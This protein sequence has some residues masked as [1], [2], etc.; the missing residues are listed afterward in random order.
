M[1][2]VLD[3]SFKAS[4]FNLQSGFYVHVWNNALGKDMKPLNLPVI[5][6]N[7]ITAVLLQGWGPEENVTCKFI[8]T[9]PAGLSWFTWMV[10]EMGGKWS[11]SCCYVIY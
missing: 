5:E 8:L 2:Q 7:N 3:Y 1:A 4:E 6:L 10:C 9:C 11:Y